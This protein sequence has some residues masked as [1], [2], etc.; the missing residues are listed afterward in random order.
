MCFNSVGDQKQP[1]PTE[2]KSFDI[3]RLKNIALYLE[4]KGTL[5]NV[6]LKRGLVSV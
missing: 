4:R 6:Q 1:V 3:L 2:K 5:K